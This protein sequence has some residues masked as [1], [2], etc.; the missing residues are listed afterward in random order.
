MQLFEFFGTHQYKKQTQQNNSE[1]FK[2]DEAEEKLADELYWFILDD[3]S[4]HKEYF[5]PLAIKIHQSVKDKEFDRSKYVKAWLP[6]VNK[7]CLLFYKEHKLSKDPK[8]VFP[9]EMR[10]AL[11]IKLANQHLT[12][13]EEGHYK[14]G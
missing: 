14:L 2:E 6:M 3:D 11:C 1:D 13:I 10:K 8:D 9:F 7:G 4:L 12:D 5:L